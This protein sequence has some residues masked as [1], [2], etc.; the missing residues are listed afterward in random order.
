MPARTPTTILAMSSEIK[1]CSLNL[2]IRTRSV[3]IPIT[4][5]LIRE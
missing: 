1:A 2:R 3:I 4:T 5:A